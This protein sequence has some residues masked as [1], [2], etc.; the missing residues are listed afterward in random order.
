MFELVLHR[1]TGSI[2]SESFAKIGLTLLTATVLS[3]LSAIVILQMLRRYWIPDSLQNPVVLAMVI[4]VFA[5]SNQLNSES[6]LV[7]ITLLGIFLANQRT[8]PIRHI[9]EFKENLRTLLIST[10]FIV[11]AS[12]VKFDAQALNSLGNARH[13]I[14]FAVNLDRPSYRRLSVDCR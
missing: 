2:A 11:L 5:L 13:N 1:S 9:I 6:G 4:F 14:C 12:R 7:T 10:L 8:V 3:G